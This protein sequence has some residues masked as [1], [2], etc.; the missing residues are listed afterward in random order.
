MHKDSTLGFATRAIHGGYDPQAH[1]GAL[2]PPIY[3]TATFTFPSAEAGAARFAGTDPG[4][5]YTRIAN[6]TL[7]LLEQRVADLEGGVDGIA[8]GSGMGAITSTLWTLLRPGDEILAH[9]TMY[10]CTYA[11]LQHG[12]EAFGV[13]VRFVDLSC[14]GVLEAAISPATRIVYCESPANPNMRL[15]DL[16]QA[17]AVC[18]RHGARLV[19]DNTYCT[20]YLQ[21]PLELGAHVVVHSATK[22][23]NGHGDVT[24]GIAVCS[25]A[26]VAE[27]IRLYG[28]KDMTGAVL[29]PHDASLILRGMKTLPLRME[30]HCD[31][32]E[33]VAELL[34]THPA[35]ETVMYPGLARFSQHALARQ[36]MRRFGGMVAFEMRG[37]V[38]AG[39]R[40]LN[41]LQLIQRAVSLGDAESLAQHPASM[42]HAAYPPEVRQASGISDGLV[43]ISVGLEDAADLLADIRQALDVTLSASR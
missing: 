33:A 17:A 21:R 14:P 36:Q 19:V 38:E 11:F 18:R 28:L 31:N 8:F 15:V 6:P 37:G 22:Y 1:E 20:P 25:E 10:G 40:F 43:R 24:A 41:A 42:T 32:A 12:L 23:L 4:Y 26:E 7:R 39:R 30:R 13:K 34:A 3:Q 2:A 9:L 16:A 27:R 35:V 29:S 5:F